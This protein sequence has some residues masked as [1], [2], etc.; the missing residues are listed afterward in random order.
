MTQT[1]AMAMGVTRHVWELDEFLDA[2]EAAEPRGVPE[3][4]PLIP[5][6]PATTARPLPSG[7]GFLRIVPGSGG[8]SAPGPGPAPAPPPV[9]PPAPAVAAPGPAVDLRQLD[10]LSWTP[11]P[12]RSLPPRGAQLD[13]FGLDF[14]PDLGT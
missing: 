7:Q 11:R 1:A 5:R 3:K 6:V 10:L 9:A 12:V 4:Q 13:L 14:D 8:P 2:L